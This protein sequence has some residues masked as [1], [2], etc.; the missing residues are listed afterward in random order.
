MNKS[1]LRFGSARKD[2]RGALN[3]G[4]L[5]LLAL[6]GV[7]ALFA[8]LAVGAY[9]GLVNGSEDVDQ[10]W[11]Q[12]ESQYKRR[13]DLIP[14]L[15]ETVKGAA[16]FEQSTIT[17]VTEARASVGR[18]QTPSEVP[19]DPAKLEEYMRAQNQLGSALSRL[20]VVAEQYPQLKATQNFLALQDQLEGT[21]NRIAVAREDYTLAV[22]GY[23]TRV[24]GFPGNLLAGLFGFATRP[25]LSVPEAEQATPKVDFGGK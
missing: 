24:R 1:P 9:N 13:F 20:L 5:A 22:K 23:N 11:A 18:V 8:L 25:Q 14:N 21:E 2:Q 17:Q 16:D 15:V 4:C 7:F 19:S 10:K 6:G 12:V 3:K